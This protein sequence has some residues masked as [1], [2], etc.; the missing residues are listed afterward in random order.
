[1]NVSI[2]ALNYPIYGK[3]REEPV[4]SV[5]QF[6]LFPP[7]LTEGTS[8]LQASDEDENEVDHE[9]NDDDDDNS[10]GNDK[11]VEEEDVNLQVDENEDDMN[12]FVLNGCFQVA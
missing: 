9:K 2:D 12:Q 3:V 10:S 1:M 4:N 11:D 8:S 6:T 7:N 5:S